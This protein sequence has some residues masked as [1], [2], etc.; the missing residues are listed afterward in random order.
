LGSFEAAVGDMPSPPGEAEDGGLSSP[1]CSCSDGRSGAGTDAGPI[2]L[3]LATTLE[4]AKTCMLA[5]FPFAAMGSAF[6][7][8]GIVEGFLCA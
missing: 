5:L 8:G 2:T 3:E 4:L 6:L 7:G 1:S